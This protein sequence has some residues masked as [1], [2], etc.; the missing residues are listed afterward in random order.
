MK[1]N[2][3][4]IFCCIYQ[5]LDSSG[6]KIS[7]IVSKPYR[8][9]LACHKCIQR[10][11]PHANF[12]FG[13]RKLDSKRQTRAERDRL[14]M[15]AEITDDIP[16]EYVRLS[17]HDSPNT[18]VVFPDRAINVPDDDKK[19]SNIL[20]KAEG[21]GGA[22]GD[23]STGVQLSGIQSK[24]DTTTLRLFGL[25]IDA[26]GEGSKDDSHDISKRSHYDAN[27][28]GGSNRRTKSAYV[29]EIGQESY[30]VSERQRVN[31]FH[32]EKG[33]TYCL[34]LP[35]GLPELWMLGCLR[36]LV[37]SDE[38]ERYYVSNPQSKSD[39]WVLR[40]TTTKT[41]LSMVQKCN[42]T[43]GT[44]WWG[45]ETDCI[46]ARLYHTTQS[47]SLYSGS[48]PG[49]HYSE[50]K[51]KFVESKRQKCTSCINSVLNPL[52]YYIHQMRKRILLLIEGRVNLQRCILEGACESIDEEVGYIPTDLS[53]F[54]KLPSGDSVT[55]AL[56]PA[57]P[58]KKWI[59]PFRCMQQTLHHAS[60][61]E[62]QVRLSLPAK[63]IINLHIVSSCVRCILG[64]PEIERLEGKVV[65]Y[66]PTSLLSSLLFFPEAVYVQELA[67]KC[68][69]ECEWISGLSEPICDQL[70]LIEQVS[71]DDPSIS[72]IS[73]PSFL[74]PPSDPPYRTKLF[75]D[76][77]R[78]LQADSSQEFVWYL[79]FGIGD[80]KTKNTFEDLALCIAKVSNTYVVSASS[81]YLLTNHF[82]YEHLMNICPE[83]ESHSIGVNSFR[84][85]EMGSVAQ[86][87]SYKA[88]ANALQ[89]S[90][91]KYRVRRQK[92]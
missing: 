69:E 73:R 10:F 2:T 7:V 42:S 13:F 55:E 85:I 52:F 56:S 54:K 15:F 39:R 9:I 12:T 49:F 29:D 63:D 91:E 57:L 88:V 68:K 20:A 17:C 5:T 66:R 78:Y 25:D 61:N 46:V 90:R 59:A 45:S 30:D 50:L 31:N 82:L 11:I 72:T 6:Y 28:A 71:P 77:I 84:H 16:Y 27:L 53:N 41:P 35:L 62:N 58:V 79:Q 67:I 70:R 1:I 75:H 83:I 32:E 92:T 8:K 33:R 36:C 89:Y 22:R 87:L 60:K 40:H 76:V 26:G 34:L 14:E 47:K 81:W 38:D 48:F 19:L 74:L 4:A 51:V 80:R 21:T 65:N 24:Q 44:F 64:S 3:I 23:I 43:C 86:P 37:F 18:C